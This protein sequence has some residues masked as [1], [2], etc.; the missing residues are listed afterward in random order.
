MLNWHIYRDNVFIAANDTLHGAKAWAKDNIAYGKPSKEHW[1][2][3]LKDN[4]ERYWMTV[5]EFTLIGFRAKW[6]KFPL[7]S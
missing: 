5:P 7:E 1:L 2:I 6:T 4:S 3:T